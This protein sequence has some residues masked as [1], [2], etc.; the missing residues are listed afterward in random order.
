MHHE[1]MIIASRHTF[2]YSKEKATTIRAPHPSYFLFP[3]LEIVYR[4][5]TYALV[6]VSEMNIYW[7]NQILDSMLIADYHNK[8]HDLSLMVINF[9]VETN[10]RTYYLWYGN[11]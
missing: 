3:P 9:C 7:R 8:P 2:P 5:V 1:F 11:N 6:L 10:T 4:N